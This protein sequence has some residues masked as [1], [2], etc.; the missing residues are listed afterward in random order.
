MAAAAFEIGVILVLILAN[1]ALSM[2][3]A[4]ILSSR[5]MRLQKRAEDGDGAAGAALEIATEPTRMLSTVQLGITLIGIFAGAYGGAALAEEIAPVLQRLPLISPHAEAV[6]VAIVVVGITFFSVIIGELVPKRVALSNPERIAATV[7]RPM[8]FFSKVA[9]PAVW[10]LSTSTNALLWLLRVR[11]VEESPVT[12]EEINIL[13]RQGTKLGTFEAAEQELVERVFRLADRRVS[14]LITPRA[15]IVWVDV[16]D[17]VEQSYRVMAASGH[18]YFPVFKDTRDHVIGLVSVKTLWAAMLEGGAPDLAE[19]LS[20]PLFVP[21]ST[22]AF[23]LLEQFRQ[24]RSHIAIVVDEYGGVQG[25]VTLNDVLGELVGDVTYADALDS[26]EVVRRPDG[27]LLLGGMLSLDECRDLL[28]VREFPGETD[29]TYQTLGG[30]VMTMLGRL[31][32][33]GD[34]IEVGP[35]RL[36]VVDMDERRVDKVLAVARRQG[37]STRWGHKES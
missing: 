21:H 30:L 26:P 27:S 34:S 33:E 32:V 11:K 5:R 16:D 29:G 37:I 31:P 28:K 2:S 1:G 13:I 35:W 18:S 15:E 22:S 25:L 6:S 7:A 14:G 24:A 8:R 20:K 9:A 4:A 12:E 17:P 23:K 3:E 36:E 10:L 19:L